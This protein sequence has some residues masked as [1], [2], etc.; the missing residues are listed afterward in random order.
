[1]IEFVVGTRRVINAM[2]IASSL[3]PD[4]KGHVEYDIID[5]DIWDG[6]KWITEFRGGILVCNEASRL[7]D[8]VWDT[9]QTPVRAGR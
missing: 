3:G 8:S 4:D 9:V 2:M 7:R 6:D 1:M 5:S